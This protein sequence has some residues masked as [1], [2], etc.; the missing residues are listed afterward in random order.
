MLNLALASRSVLLVILVLVS[1]VTTDD[2]RCSGVPN[3]S[4]IPSQNACYLY[5]NCIDGNVYPLVCPDDDWFSMDQQRCVPQDE[6]DCAL[7]DP[8]VLPELP[9]REPSAICEAVPNFHYVASEA[10][11]QWYYQCIDQFAY[12][13]SCPRYL[14]FDEELQRCG[15][16]YDVRCEGDSP[17]TTSEFS[18]S[19]PST[20]SELST[21]VSSTTSE[22][23]TSGPPQANL[24]PQDR[25]L[26][27]ICPPRLRWIL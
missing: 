12:L 27:P 14:W 22:L 9:P 25:Q 16:R 8:P 5:Y 11:C 26:Q 21:P 15:S 23:T 24:P 2:E 3:L 4:Y 1:S 20:T 7:T 17:S 6:S 19:A 13:L 18:T 10:S